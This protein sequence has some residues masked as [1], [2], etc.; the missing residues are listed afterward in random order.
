MR[1]T[2][3]LRPGTVPWTFTAIPSPVI[4]AL[5]LACL[6]SASVARARPVDEDFQPWLQLLVDGRSA[7]HLRWSLDLQ[8]RWLD[9]PRA[10]D[11]QTG[12]RIDSSN[13]L[14]LVRPGLGWTL[15]DWAA[16]WAGYAYQ[17]VLYDDDKLA[18][19]RD[20]DEH[21]A[22]EQLSISHAL[23]EWK[24]GLRSRLE[25]R[26]RTKGPGD[27]D[28]A[29]RFRQQARAAYDLTG[30]WKWQ[31]IVS[32]EIL[33]HLN[34]TEYPTKIGLDQN[35]AFI[36]IGYQP[37][38]LARLELGYLNQFVRRY[39]DPHQVNHVLSIQLIITVETPF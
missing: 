7:E 9:V 14:V 23:A 6:L 33:F 5:A 38:P 22:W 17:P 8:S 29:H 20:V 36:G 24:M 3:R 1:R 18:D 15:S 11:S 28:W 35:R 34:D 25:Q 27:G 2:S 26:Y 30:D 37:V 13:T 16:V 12:K 32:D 4:L 21:R 31:A 10:N 39:T 19:S